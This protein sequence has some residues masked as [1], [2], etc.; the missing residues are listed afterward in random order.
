MR[1]A[2][3]EANLT[4]DAVDYVNAHATGTVIGDAAECLA[5]EE[6]F[7]AGPLVS[8]LK[9]HLGHTMA[10]SGAIE[11]AATLE[12]M[13]QGVVIPTRNLKAPAANVGINFP[14]TVPRRHVKISIKNNFGLGG[15]NTTIV[16][17]KY[18]E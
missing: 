7:G 8:S 1:E 17:R 9:G 16:L 10:A 15:I 5:I 18:N 3:R 14:L 13:R 4:T 12:M 6:V 11:I 2:L